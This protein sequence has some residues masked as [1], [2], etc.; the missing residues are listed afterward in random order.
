MNAASRIEKSIELKAPVSR[1]WNAVTDAGE[2][3]RWFGIELDG[4]FVEGKAVAGTFR[5]SLN[6]AAIIEYQK[7]LGLTPSKVRIPEQGMTFCTVERIE[8]QQYFS[9]RW[10][11]YGVDAE[12]DPENEPTTLVE[13]RL[14]PVA[15]GTRLTITESGFDRVP[16]HR[17]ERAFLMNEGGWSAQA[18]N[19]KRYVE[20]D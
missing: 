7:R 9:F 1:V 4:P 12:I 5:Q 8:P 17:R 14:A 6:E 20:N 18:E 15:D 2:F 10:I 13:F 11:P 16:E 19:I 3:G